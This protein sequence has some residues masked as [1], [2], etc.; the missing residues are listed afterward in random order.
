VKPVFPINYDL[1][2][3]PDFDK[4]K[5]R[6]REKVLI[7]TRN[8]RQIVLNSAELEIKD[9]QIIINKKTIRPK[10]RL[11]VKNEELILFLRKR[12]QERPYF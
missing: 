3:E 7:Q 9:C 1:E 4:F 11:D 12:S 10:V 8:T 6:G 5:F 2:F